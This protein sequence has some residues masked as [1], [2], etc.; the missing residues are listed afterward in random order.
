VEII[1]KQRIVGTIVI[2]A[3]LSLILPII[4]ISK[5]QVFNKQLISNIPSK[6]I[7]KI[8]LPDDGF[9]PKTISEQ[10]IEPLA[11]DVV[12]ADVVVTNVTKQTAGPDSEP[13][14]TSGNKTKLISLRIPLSDE[15]KAIGVKESSQQKQNT[16]GASDG[17][18]EKAS[19][20]K[21]PL[22]KLVASAPHGELS[23][24]DL[25]SIGEVLKNYINDDSSLDKTAVSKPQ[26]SGAAA[27][28]EGSSAKTFNDASTG[29]TP[30]SP[31]SV[32]SKLVTP[33]LSVPL[34][35]AIVIKPKP[36][37]QKIAYLKE[38][39]KIKFKPAKFNGIDVGWVVQVGSFAKKSNASKLQSKLKKRGHNSYVEL[40][41][42]KHGVIYRVRVGPQRDQ[43]RAKIVQS[44]ILKQEKLESIV[45]R[46]PR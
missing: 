15:P 37:A 45:L 31:K 5:D 7:F 36:Q 17:S 32:T 41:K 44:K 34:S 3:I 16:L 28:N 20:S 24:P 38:Q 22:G 29:L 12:I 1:L 14:T 10:S 39:N 46:Y 6:P 43:A 42:S 19:E 11:A 9:K 40:A 2:I 21:L 25:A 27:T 33:K 4:V 18:I 23:L 26:K 8:S 35:E 13:L 30:Q